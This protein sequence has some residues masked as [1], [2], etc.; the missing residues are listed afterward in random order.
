MALK[1]LISNFQVFEEYGKELCIIATNLNMMNAEYFH[2][3]TTPDMP[4][5]D[6]V[7]MSMGIPGK[8]RWEDPPY[9]HTIN[10]ANSFIE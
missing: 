4:V 5:R 9:F 8:S 7:R 1:M 10:V 2:R 6:A 3:K